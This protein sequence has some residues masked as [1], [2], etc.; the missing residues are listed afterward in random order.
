MQKQNKISV[1]GQ[2]LW[3]LDNKEKQAQRTAMDR[4]CN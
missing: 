1:N 2:K 4:V 3:S